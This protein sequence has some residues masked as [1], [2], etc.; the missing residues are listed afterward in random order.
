MEAQ[1]LRDLGLESQDQD[2]DADN[3]IISLK[4]PR[5]VL[6]GTQ[7]TPELEVEILMEILTQTIITLCT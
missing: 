2:D 6:I 1:Y 7:E 3:E 5:S 4:K